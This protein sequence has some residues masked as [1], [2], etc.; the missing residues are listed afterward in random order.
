MMLT[1]APVSMRKSAT[2]SFTKNAAVKEWAVLFAAF[3]AGLSSLNAMENC[4]LNVK[5]SCVVY[6]C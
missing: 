3:T 6:F 4:L 2:L 5:E 1:A